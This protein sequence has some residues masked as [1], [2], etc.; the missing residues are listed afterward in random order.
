MRNQT[1]IVFAMMLLSTLS[2]LGLDSTDSIEVS[3][4]S[5]TAARA[6]STDVNITQ[7]EWIGPSYYCNP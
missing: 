7:L 4:T 1:L 3:T 6:P 2:P 5:S